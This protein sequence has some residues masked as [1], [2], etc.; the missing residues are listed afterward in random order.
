[1]LADDLRS[2]ASDNRLAEL[3]ERVD[4]DLL[5]FEVGTDALDDLIAWPEDG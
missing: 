1:L 5:D 3:P 4:H 2:N